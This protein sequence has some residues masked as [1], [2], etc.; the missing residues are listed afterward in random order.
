MIFVP[1]GWCDIIRYKN[2][3]AS[4]TYRR[5]Y[6]KTVKLGN[7]AKQVPAVIVGCMRFSQMSDGDDP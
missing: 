6:M 4:N 2:I 5:N 1:F 7:T 3:I